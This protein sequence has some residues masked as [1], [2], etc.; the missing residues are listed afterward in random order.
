MFIVDE[1]DAELPEFKRRTDK[2]FEADIDKMLGLEV[3]VKRLENLNVTKAMGRDKVSPMVLKSCAGEWAKVLQIIFK[4]SYSEGVVPIEWGEANVTPLFKKGS[5]LE[6]A[7]YRP[8][9]LTSIC[10][11]LMEGI[12]KDDLMEY[13]YENNLIA[14]QQHGFVRRRAC[15]TN[16]LVSKQNF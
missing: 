15:V 2:T 9:S 13:F 1:E 3:I 4:K 8:V 6:A 12:L 7:N 14:K 5:K 11:K 16:L 10:C